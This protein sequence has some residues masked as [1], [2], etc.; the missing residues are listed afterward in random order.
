MTM[1][2]DKKQPWV[3]SLG[4]QAVQEHGE[5]ERATEQLAKE[6]ASGSTQH[7]QSSPTTAAQNIAMVSAQSNQ[8]TP[9]GY[10][11][12]QKRTTEAQIQEERREKEAATAGLVRP[13]RSSEEERVQESVIWKA[14][15]R[16]G[17]C[18]G[19]NCPC[20]RANRDNIWDSPMTTAEE[21]AF[22]ARRNQTFVRVG[23]KVKCPECKG[24]GAIYGTA[25]GQV[26][27][28]GLCKGARV[29]TV[30]A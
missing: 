17:I 27:L 2:N 19:P 7:P 5:R 1:A 9:P 3:K 30:M 25:S 22:G 6:R 20:A 13:V 4:A 10:A 21:S 16:C 24:E 12:A 8:Y 26:V 28:C 15:E 23:D 14:R 11:E 29:A 18:G